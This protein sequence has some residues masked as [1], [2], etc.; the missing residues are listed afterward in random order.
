[1]RDNAQDA[2]LPRRIGDRRDSA[3]STATSTAAAASSSSASD[4]DLSGRIY[5]P[6][7]RDLSGSATA[8]TDGA[9]FRRTRLI[10]NGRRESAGRLLQRLATSRRFRFPL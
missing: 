7:G 4:G 5:G 1:V 2:N 9:P 8:S 3:L 6:R 10:F